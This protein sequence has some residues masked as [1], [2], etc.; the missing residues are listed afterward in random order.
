M[1]SAPPPS[2][3]RRRGLCYFERRLTDAST[4][5]TAPQERYPSRELS[6]HDRP[7]ALRQDDA[8][9]ATLERGLVRPMRYRVALLG[10]TSFERH[11]L[12]FCFREAGEREPAYELVATLALADFVVADGDSEQVVDSVVR[13]GRIG[14]TAFV[15]SLAPPHGAMAHVS[16]PIDPARILRCLDELVARGMAALESAPPG[17]SPLTQ[18]RGDAQPATP[19]SARE[20]HAVAKAEARAAARRARLTH[21][22]R[23]SAHESPLAN[24]LVLDSNDPAREHLCALLEVF[25]FCTYP[26]RTVAEANWMAET[27][28]F[29]A[30]FLDMDFGSAD[31]GMAIDLCRWI[32]QASATSRT[33]ALIVVCAST[34]PADRVRAAL[35]GSDVVLA[36][37]VGRGDVARALEH[38]GVV[39]PADA[40]RS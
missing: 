28:S 16:R 14:T 1:N 29:T 10:F 36:K 7:S 22:A 25:G 35:A 2:I 6:G 19:D 37:P 8:D 21:A 12:L 20:G 13:H 5:T 24:V 34:H 23:G 15:G 32:K 4:R 26:V 11:A 31:A 27:Q 39:L 30:A 17:T 38:C 3:Q 40:R 33:C 18:L 9:D